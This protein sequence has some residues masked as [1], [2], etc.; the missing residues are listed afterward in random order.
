MPLSNQLSQPTMRRFEIVRVAL[1]AG[2]AIQAAC[3]L[4]ARL[5]VGDELGGP[6]GGMSFATAL[7]QL[8]I[9]GGVAVSVDRR[10]AAPSETRRLPRVLL[11]IG[12]AVVFNEALGYLPVLGGAASPDAAASAGSRCSPTK[13]SSRHSTS[14]EPTTGFRNATERTRSAGRC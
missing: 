13:A 4:V 11:W 14:H 1:L 8:L 3:V 2:A 10:A 9:V 7:V 6:W 5:T 12:A